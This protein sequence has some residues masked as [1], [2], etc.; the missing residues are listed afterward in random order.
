M[1]KDRYGLIKLE[2]ARELRQQV[3]FNKQFG[4]FMQFDRQHAD[5]PGAFPFRPC[6]VLEVHLHIDFMH[7]I[8]LTLIKA[9]DLTLMAH[10]G[11]ALLQP[12]LKVAILQFPKISPKKPHKPNLILSEV[13]LL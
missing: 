1:F 5:K 4:A 8:V 3:P 13:Y 11:P 9:S 6:A 2:E 10:L 12:P 7:K